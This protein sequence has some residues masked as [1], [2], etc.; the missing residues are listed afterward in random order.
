MAGMY[1]LPLSCFVC[2][3]LFW[4]TVLDF[5]KNTGGSQG[6][7]GGEEHNQ[8]IS[9]M[10]MCRSNGASKIQDFFFFL[11][12]HSFCLLG[13]EKR[14]GRGGAVGHQRSKLFR[15]WQVCVKHRDSN[16]FREGGQWSGVLETNRF[17]PAVWM[18]GGGAKQ[19]VQGSWCGRRRNYWRETFQGQHFT[20]RSQS[21]LVVYCH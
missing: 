10:L 16:T 21:I 17:R 7:G 19:K 1:C 3:F 13:S 15:M 5:S 20:L 2:M 4:S 18:R 12:L 14:R 11:S 6:G 9:C 8:V